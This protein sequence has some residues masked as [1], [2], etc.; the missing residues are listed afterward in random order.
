MKRRALFLIGIALGISLLLLMFA[1][2]GQSGIKYEKVFSSRQDDFILH[3]RVEE[4]NKGIRILRSL[5]YVG[6]DTVEIKHQT[7]LISV[8]LQNRNHDYTGSTVKKT[9][10]TGNIYYQEPVIIDVPIEKESELY[11]QAKFSVDD[12]WIYMNHVETLIFN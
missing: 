6:K 3:I 8:S 9:L 11:V 1:H 4:M 2:E 10:K 7:P 5:Q 12:E